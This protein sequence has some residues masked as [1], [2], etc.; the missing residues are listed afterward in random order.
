M[1]LNKI[2]QIPHQWLLTTPQRALDEAYRAAIKIKDIE[3]K[4]FQGQKV[5]ITRANYGTGASNYFRGEVNGYLQTIR[6]R[7]TEFKLSRAITNTFRPNHPL[8]TALSNDL[9]LEKLNIIDR[10]VSK[11]EIPES[12]LLDL[13]PT[14]NSSNITPVNSST[15]K[16]S[17]K[18]K[19][20]PARSFLQVGNLEEEEVR[21]NK[22]ESA[23]RKTGV[24]PRSFLNTLSRIKQEID[25]QSEEIEEA[26]L[27]KYRTSRY[28]TA[29]SIKFLLMLIIIPLLTQQLSKTFLISPLVNRYFEQHPQFVF[30]NQ[31]LEEEAFT[32][33]KH[34]EESLRYRGMIGLSPKLSQEEIEGEI[35]KKAEELT[36]EYRRRGL[37][38]IA[39]VFADLLSLVAF[40]IVVA[41]SRRE[42]A[43]LKSFM[44]GIVYNL[45][46]SAKAFLIILFTD[47]FVGFHSPHGWEVILESVARHFGLPESRNF[48]FLF[49]ATFPV[50]LDTILKYWIFRYLNRMSPS[51]VATYRNMNE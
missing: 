36:D 48:N 40:A 31:D 26:V 17:K 11:Y 39:N 35:K 19:S 23:S 20:A 32:E 4:H 2:F 24:L 50:I 33:L 51:A 9:T 16:N 37:N 3:D 22:N 7:L 29:I 13:P 49:I 14:A 42:I 21:I 25:P 5:S 46:D 28:K 47:M 41:C 30:I 10:V 12:E 15:P 6:I 44:D 34:H 45:S 18:L 27:R 38:A 8:V 43:I 1:N